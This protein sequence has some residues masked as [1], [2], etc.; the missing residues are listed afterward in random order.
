MKLV[1]VLERKKMNEFAFHPVGQGLFYTGS[2]FN[3]S[4]NFVYDYGGS[5]NKND[6]NKIIDEY[7]DKIGQNDIDFI[8]IS[9]L[10]SDY[11]NGLYELI[12][13]CKSKGI[14]IK[15]LILPYLY[16]F[17]NVVISLLATDIFSKEEKNLKKDMNYSVL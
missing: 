9:H 2:I 16:G 3:G 14:K 13:S 4:Y 10:H 1:F 8:I 11:F 6:F 5:I 12:D 17:E 15:K 7:T